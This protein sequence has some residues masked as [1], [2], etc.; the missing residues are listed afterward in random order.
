[1]ET[2]LHNAQQSSVTR[3][4]PSSLHMSS[5]SSLSVPTVL[6]SI[7]GVWGVWRRIQRRQACHSFPEPPLFSWPSPLRAPV[8]P[9]DAPAPT[10]PAARSPPPRYPIPRP[11]PVAWL[12]LGALTS[13]VLRST[14]WS[15]QLLLFSPAWRLWPRRWWRLPPSGSPVQG[16]FQEEVYA[17]IW[18]AAGAELEAMED[19]G[20]GHRR[21]H[22]WSL[23]HCRVKGIL[24]G[25]QWTLLL[26]RGL[27]GQ[28]DVKF[29]VLFM[30]TVTS[31]GVWREPLR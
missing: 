27:W 11:A 23:R 28:K 19:R 7:R 8:P 31:Y 3:T 25:H 24:G 21:H 1:M 17:W 5:V 14:P 10:D 2:L 22:R 29:M 30:H 16:L 26:C 4:P 20:W 12:I 15:W 9:P 18:S 6:S 13:P